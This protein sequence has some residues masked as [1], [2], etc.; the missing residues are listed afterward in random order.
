[1]KTMSL[2]AKLTF[3]CLAVALVS[4]SGGVIGYYFLTEVSHRYSIVSQENLP[5]MKELGGLRSTIR[6]LR[7][8]VRSMGLEGNSPA[9]VEKYVQRSLEQVALFEQHLDI[10]KKIDAKALERES[11]KN[12][13]KSWEEFKSFGSHLIELSKN[14]QENHAEIVNQIRNVCETK[15]ENV[16]KPLLE[17]TEYQFKLADQ[18]VALATASKNN[19]KQL[20]L[21]V[22]VLSILAAGL[23]SFAVSSRISKT[24]KMIC[25]SLAMNSKDVQLAATTLTKVSTSVHDSSSKTASMIESSTASMTQIS[26]MVNLSSERAAEAAS[27]SQASKRSAEEGSRAIGQLM[28]SVNNISESS[29]K[30]QDIIDIIE[31]ISFQT[32]LLALNASV[33]AARAGEAGKSFAV[34]ADAVRTLAARSSTSAKE[35]SELINKSAEFIKEG[36]KNASDSQLVLEQILQSV[37]KVTSFNNEIAQ[38]S[39][40]QKLGIQQVGGTLSQLDEASQDNSRA[41]EEVSHTASD[42]HNK[43]ASV[44]LLIADLRLL[45]EGKKAA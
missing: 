11:F 27:A 7:I 25:D 22:S 16:Y 12:L 42:L 18:S 37:D 41:S 35:I 30:M 3:L 29:K 32:N 33:E 40:E 4:A 26:S 8:H 10:Y 13:T 43:T 9:E 36:V 20:A 28:T 19:A 39:E 1:M 17:E 23:V 2:K 24:V 44:D 31:D 14:Y 38:S 45:V 34:V 15:A 5:A 21:W 6:E